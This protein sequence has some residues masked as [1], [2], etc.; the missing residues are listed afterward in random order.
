MFTSISYFI[1]KDE[2]TYN[3]DETQHY[4]SSAQAESQNMRYVSN[5]WTACEKQPESLFKRPIYN[6]F[7]FSNIHFECLFPIMT[8]FCAKNFCVLVGMPVMQK[9]I[10]KSRRSQFSFI[11]EPIQKNKSN[12]GFRCSQCERNLRLLLIYFMIII[13]SQCFIL[14]TSHENM[15][16]FD[17]DD[18]FSYRNYG[19]TAD[20]SVAP[21]AALTDHQPLVL[22]HCRLILRP[23]A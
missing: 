1:Y 5:C 10:S 3:Q 6:Q 9:C 22:Q 11:I 16:I 21:R 17:S 23:P 2:K 18:F 15:V 12:L 20:L 13:Q 4:C 14:I 19:A 8:K 7:Y